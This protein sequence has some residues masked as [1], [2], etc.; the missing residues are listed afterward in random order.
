MLPLGLCRLQLFHPSPKQCRVLAA[1]S[2]TAG[3]W[4]N[5]E[6]GKSKWCFVAKHRGW[7]SAGMR[8][9]LNPELE[10]LKKGYL[11]AERSCRHRFWR[12]ARGCCGRL[13]LLGSSCGGW[14]G[15]IPPPGPVPSPLA[16]STHFCRASHCK[17]P[18]SNTSSEATASS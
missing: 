5:K 9:S 15:A 13:Q 10:T 6:G 2:A 8:E 18:C 11:R 17:E 1:A 16:V 4:S 14:Q 12:R 3:Q 7:I